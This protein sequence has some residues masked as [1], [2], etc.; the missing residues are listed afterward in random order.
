MVAAGLGAA[1]NGLRP[2]VDLNFVDF[3]L[4]GFDK[5]DGLYISLQGQNLTN[6]DTLHT[7][8]DPRQ[9]TKWQTFGSNYLLNVNYK[10][11]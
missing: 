5:L 10:F 1:V 4:G 7:D 6:E 2:V 9:V 3:G 11:R 8:A